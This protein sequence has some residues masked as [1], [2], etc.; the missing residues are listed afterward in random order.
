VFRQAIPVLHVRSAVAAEEFYCGRLGFRRS[1]AY[2]PNDPEPDP[3]YMGLA[4]DGACLHVSSFAGDG[5][6]G[7]VVYLA[8]DDVDALYAELRGADVR[9]DLA[10]T[11]QTWGNRE[12]YVRDPDGNAIRFSRE[13]E[14]APE[15]RGIRIARPADLPDIVDVHVRSSRAAYAALP[16]AVVEGVSLEERRERWRSVLTDRDSRVWVAVDGPT[17]VGFC[18]LLL[19]PAGEEPLRRAEIASIYVAPSHWRRGFGR[20]LVERARAVAAAAGREVLTLRVF[21]ANHRARAAY[22][23]LGFRPGAP[24]TTHERTGLPLMEYVVHL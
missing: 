20:R 17:I 22:E 10:P 15:L 2:R 5:V 13:G 11:D 1:F 7:G 16:V 21:A 6:A 8:V 24:T 4:R 12:M 19:P 18:H 23:A 3:C 9:I 14:G